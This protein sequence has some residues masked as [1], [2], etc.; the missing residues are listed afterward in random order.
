MLRGRYQDY[1][2]MSDKVVPDAQLNA[3]MELV[4]DIQVRNN[5]SVEYVKEH[6][7]FAS[8]KLCPGNYFPWH[9]FIDRLQ[10]KAAFLDIRKHWAKE[11]IEKVAVQGIMNGFPDG[12][13]KPNLSV[14]RAEI[15]TVAT[16]TLE[17]LQKMLQ[18]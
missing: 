8:Y 13:F 15:A 2:S 9:I 1:K 16:R 11:N 4:R 18:G 7:Y 6:N 5:I 12:E 17:V 3:L 14:T 10:E